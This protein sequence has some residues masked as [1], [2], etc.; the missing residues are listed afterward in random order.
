MA[1]G[2]RETSRRLPF[3]SLPHTSELAYQVCG[4]DRKAIFLHSAQA[5]LDLWFG[6]NLPGGVSATPHR[7]P[8]GGA[9][10][11]GAKKK[12]S[13]KGIDYENLLVN[14]LNHLIFLFSARE[15]VSIPVRILSVS[16]HQLKAEIRVLALDRKRHPPVREVKSA[17][18]HRL[19]IRREG[20]LYQ[21]NLVFDV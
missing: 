7:V 20:P 12:V 15:Q 10:P 21:T 18:Y 6:E 17:T 14:W 16:S 1:G 19:C 13:L 5:L 3:C 9:R 11:T 4:K 2:S 8:R